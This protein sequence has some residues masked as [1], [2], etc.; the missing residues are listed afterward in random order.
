MSGYSGCR[1]RGG[2]GTHYRGSNMRDI[3]ER[4]PD[5]RDDGRYRD[6]RPRQDDRPYENRRGR[7]DSGQNQRGRGGGYTQ[8]VQDEGL[9]PLPS[10]VVVPK[11]G[12]RLAL[13]VPLPKGKLTSSIILIRVIIRGLKHQVVSPQLGRPFNLLVNHF[14]IQSLP[15]IKTPMK[16]N[17]FNDM[18]IS[19]SRDVWSWHDSANDGSIFPAN[20]ANDSTSSST[21]VSGLL[22][23][24]L[25]KG[26]KPQDIFHRCDQPLDTMYFPQLSKVCKEDSAVDCN[27]LHPRWSYLTIDSFTSQNTIVGELRGKIGHMS[28]V[29]VCA[30]RT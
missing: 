4:S 7:Y 23:Q 14:I 19:A 10:E 27:G 24:R 5:R 28:N 20:A 2:S 12:G 18:G 30:N 29:E 16:A 1:Y 3:R 11:S 22:V 9:P 6:D 21:G 13:D 25:R 8:H 26:K 15:T 17:F